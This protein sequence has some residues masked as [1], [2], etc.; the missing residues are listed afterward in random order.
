MLYFPS[1]QSWIECIIMPDKDFKSKLLMLASLCNT[2]MLYLVIKITLGKLRTD[3]E[4]HP[5][6]KAV[7]MVEGFL[8][9]NLEDKLFSYVS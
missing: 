9:S 4:H 7:T 5:E 3:V 6:L 1:V 8:L 2:R